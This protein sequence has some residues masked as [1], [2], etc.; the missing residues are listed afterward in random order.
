MTN[1][2]RHLLPAA[3][4]LATLSGAAHADGLYL[5]GNAGAPHWKGSINGIS[6]RSDGVG[7]NLYAGYGFMQDLAIE[8]GYARL[9]DFNGKIGRAHV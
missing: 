8:V 3:L 4:L 1:P 6:G 7:L 9:G 2:R 5:G